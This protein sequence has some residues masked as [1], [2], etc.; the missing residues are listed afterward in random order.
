MTKLLLCRT[1]HPLEPIRGIVLHNI[2]K[3]TNQPTGQSR[4]GYAIWSHSPTAAAAAAGHN[5]PETKGEDQHY[6]IFLGW[7]RTSF[8][9]PLFFLSPLFSH[10]RLLSS[11]HTTHPPT[12]HYTMEKGLVYP[13]DLCP[14]PNQPTPLCL[15]HLFWP[16]EASYHES[17]CSTT[18]L[19]STIPDITSPIAWAFDR[20]IMCNTIL[21]E[22][23][24]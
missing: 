4:K 15:K 20:T 14:T 8:V 13:S 18:V 21:H 22:S 11:N 5:S 19:D 24:Q 17:P 7:K 6:K 12:P 1:L 16:N 9:T 10:S 23:D 3:H 2:H